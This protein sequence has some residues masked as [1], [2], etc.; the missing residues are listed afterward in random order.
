MSADPSVCCLQLITMLGRINMHEVLAHK[1]IFVHT[2]D[3]VQAA[4]TAMQQLDGGE[5]GYSCT[6]GPAGDVQSRLGCKDVVPEV[7]DERSGLGHTA[8]G[9]EM[10]SSS[11]ASGSNPDLNVVVSGSNHSSPAGHAL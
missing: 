1:W 3:G 4:V 2:H 11:M 5:G 9:I 8:E 10:A 6:S 7:Q